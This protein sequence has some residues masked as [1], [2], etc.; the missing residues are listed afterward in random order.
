MYDSVTA[1]CDCGSGAFTLYQKN[2]LPIMRCKSCGVERQKIELDE[3]SLANF[4]AEDYHQNFYTHE[5]PE[6]RAAAKARLSSYGEIAKGIVLDVGSGNGAFID[7]CVDAHLEA[8]GVELDCD[9]SERFYSGDLRGLSF[10]CE[11]ADL[12]T[13]HDVLEHV[14]RPS[15]LL[16]EAYRVLSDDGHLIVEIPCFESAEGRKHWKLIEHLWFWTAE[17]FVETLKRNLF[18]VVEMR[19]PVPGKLVFICKKKPRKYTSILV[20]PGIGDIYWVMV[21]L[22]GFCK[23]YNIDLPVDVYIDA[24]DEKRRAEELV[25][26]VPFCRF[27]GYITKDVE[28]GP[29][30]LAKH[31]AANTMKAHMRDQ[32]RRALYKSAEQNVIESVDGCDYFLSFNGTM[33][34][35]V[36]LYQASPEWSP[37][38]NL[39]IFVPNLAKVKSRK[40]MGERFIM[41]SFWDHKFYQKWL[42]QM[43]AMS[44]YEMLRR[45]SYQSKVRVALCGASWDR[46]SKVNRDLLAL[47]EEGI[48]VDLVGKTT[49]YEYMALMQISVGCVGFPAGNLMLGPALK[50]PTMLIWN[51]Y[52][53]EAFWRGACN[54]GAYYRVANTAQSAEKIAD[55]FGKFLLDV[56]GASMWCAAP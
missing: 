28:R 30:D 1:E 46:Q 26:A 12:I 35:G 41:A 10:P 5:Y 39:P 9:A 40:L 49:L 18:E 24:P 22:P 52:Y 47:D 11:F 20:P 51:D 42:E 44:I 16:S 19:S 29:R 17:Q 34:A 32:A 36:D 50:V 43:P 54:P 27:K 55:Y 21:K 14:A 53:P 33:D 8:Y 56:A 31:H 25:R 4:Y 13:M 38:W 6:D 15:S 37:Q 7:E 2:G 23:A 3:E 45:I 48:F